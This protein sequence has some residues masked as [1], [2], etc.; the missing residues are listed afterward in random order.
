[1]FYVVYIPGLNG[2]HT[3]GEDDVEDLKDEI[4]SS[5]T[6]KLESLKVSLDVSTTLQH[7]QTNK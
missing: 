1:M 5:V 6:D 3:P 7:G 2:K 4:I